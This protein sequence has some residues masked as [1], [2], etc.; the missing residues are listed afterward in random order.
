MRRERPD[1]NLSPTNAVVLLLAGSLAAAALLGIEGYR[2]IRSHRAVVESTLTDFSALA[3]QRFVA[4]LDAEFRFLVLDGIDASRT[5]DWQGPVDGPP[6]AMGILRD[7]WVRFYFQVDLEA[8][9]IRTTENLGSG[10]AGAWVR[11]AVTR[12]V[13]EVLP[14]PAPYAFIPFYLDGRH[15]TAVYVVEDYRGDQRFARGFVLDVSAL[16]PF[17]SRTF[18]ETWLLP[19]TATAAYSPNSQLYASVRVPEGAILFETADRTPSRYES[20]PTLAGRATGLT[21]RVAI[22]EG[23]QDVFVTQQLSGVPAGSL[24]VL[25][26]LNAL[27]V[28][29]ALHVLRGRRRAMRERE[30][31]LITVSH[32]LRT[33]LSQIRMFVETLLLDR[34]PSQEVKDRALRVI[35]SE[36]QRLSLLVDNVLCLTRHEQRKPVL[37]P[38]PTS[39]RETL[40][41]VADSFGIAVE[42]SGSQIT[43]R[44][45]GSDTAN[46]DPDALRRILV[47]LID[48]AIKYGPSSQTIS[49]EVIA[50]PTKLKIA[51]ED[52]GPGV[53]DD[54]RELIFDRF[55]R[56]DQAG[57]GAGIGLSVV[58]N[59]V[60][61][62]GGTISCSPAPG[63]G[64]RFEVSL[65]L[66]LLP[67]ADLA[68]GLGHPKHQGS[69]K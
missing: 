44:I 22:A 39:L 41:A 55:H 63:G 49:V 69:P 48:N 15:L 32:E 13:R 11:E 60:T 57:S 66:T 21:V 47:N 56:G 51:V 58:K 16:E 42:R 67:H 28:L 12:H 62:N 40:S 54:Q 38:E 26:A 61:A 2:A 53:P 20:P 45:E 59:L 64:A 8:Q 31:F 37:R 68:I 3:A 35:D 14:G 50:D 25:F 17:F 9:T 1:T 7:E 24:A 27:L 29:A 10:E 5:I 18:E 33:P 65:R 34:A 23:F 19:T 4:A 52:E 30:A 6:S 46:I 43:W 36:S